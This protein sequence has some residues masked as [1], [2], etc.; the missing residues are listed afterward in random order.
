MPHHATAERPSAKALLASPWIPYLPRLEVSGWVLLDSQ[1]VQPLDLSPGL[2]LP[3]SLQGM[4]VG[5]LRTVWLDPFEGESW[6]RQGAV[7]CM[8]R[9]GPP[10]RLHLI[11]NGDR[12]FRSWSPED[13]LEGWVSAL[14]VWAY[15]RTGRLPETIEGWSD[16]IAFTQPTPETEEWTAE[17]RSLFQEAL[18]F[19]RERVGLGPGETTPSPPRKSG[20]DS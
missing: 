12:S 20:G 5:G 14:L 6:G 1:S 9:E 8:G 13:V 7:L 18:D 3:Q 15:D 11:R 17:A 10:A 4:P 19:A 2:S 16:V